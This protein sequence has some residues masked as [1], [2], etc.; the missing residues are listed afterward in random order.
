M[1]WN[2]KRVKREQPNALT[3]AEMDALELAI[4]YKM[5]EP[6]DQTNPLFRAWQKI[7]RITQEDRPSCG[8]K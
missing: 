2:L 1:P 8:G 5:G 6:Q 7:V 3:D 4:R